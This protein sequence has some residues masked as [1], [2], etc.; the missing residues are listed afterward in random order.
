MGNVEIFMK[1]YSLDNV[2]M[3]R[4]KSHIHSPEFDMKSEKPDS[5]RDSHSF[6]PLPHTN[7]E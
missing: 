4:S 1:E 5:D 2:D 7:H 6:S 3:L